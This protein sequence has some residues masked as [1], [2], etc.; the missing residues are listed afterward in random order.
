MASWFLALRKFPTERTTQSS[1]TG[2]WNGCSKCLGGPVQH[3]H[4]LFGNPGLPLGKGCAHT[5]TDGE[6]PGI[7]TIQEKVHKFAENNIAASIRSAV[8]GGDYR[9]S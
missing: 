1:P 9:R 2:L 5:V 6:Y 7:P 3:G 4:D 8:L